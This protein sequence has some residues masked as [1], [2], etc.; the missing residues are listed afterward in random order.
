MGW[1]N[2]PIRFWRKLSWNSLSEVTQLINSR[3]GL[4]SGLLNH[5]HAHIILL[6]SC[7]V[8]ANLTIIGVTRVETPGLGAPSQACSEYM[9]KAP[10]EHS[11]KFSW[12]LPFFPEKWG[13]LA[14]RAVCLPLLQRPTAFMTC[15]EQGQ[16]GFPNMSPSSCS[17]GQLQVGPAIQP[18]WRT[19]WIPRGRRQRVRKVS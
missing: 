19:W 11:S 8:W 6:S 5:S 1:D 3:A 15:L 9:A 13:T 2:P 14:L 4:S 7:C 18:S 17:C 12:Q 10:L 16:P